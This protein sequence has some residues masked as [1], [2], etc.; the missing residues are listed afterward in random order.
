MVQ[1]GKV[2]IDEGKPLA[3]EVEVFKEETDDEQR[4]LL[5]LEKLT[6]PLARLT[7]PKYHVFTAEDPLSSLMAEDE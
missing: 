7:K 5:L 4:I 3:A 1:D 6:L 2:G